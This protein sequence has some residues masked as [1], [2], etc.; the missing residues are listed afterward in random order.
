MTVEGLH[1]LI[2]EAGIGFALVRFPPGSS[3]SEAVAAMREAAVAVRADDP[4][5]GPPRVAVQPDRPDDLSGYDRVNTTP[6]VLAGLLALLAIGTTAHGLLTA[7][8]RRRRDLGLMKAIG[9]TRRQVS[10]AVAWQATTVA[11]FALLI[12]LPVGVALGRWL[13]T[14]LADRLGIPSEPVTPVPAVLLAVP[15][16]FV[17][18]NLVAAL[19]G[20]HAGAVPAATVLRAE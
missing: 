1:R 4:S 13:W 10:A 3:R 19:P 5:V 12:G 15:A 16:T 9:F 20:R 8:R 18:L 11:A 2:P 6:L 14:L 17:L 7:T